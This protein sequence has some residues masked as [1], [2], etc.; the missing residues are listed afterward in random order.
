MN[1]V[2]H[3]LKNQKELSI[4]DNK[5]NEPNKGFFMEKILGIDL[6]TT[7][8]VMAI[9]EHSE[10][11]VIPNNRGDRLMASVVAYTKNE[12]ILVGKSAK[13]QSIVNS[14]RTIASIKRKMGTQ[15]SITIGNKTLTPQEISAKILGK[16]KE[17]AEGYYGEEIKKAVITVPAYFNDNQRQ[18]TKDAGRLAGLEVV[19]IINEPTAAALAYGFNSNDEKIV[20]VYDLGGGTF[21]VS[22]L[23][24][25]SGVF[26]VKATCGNNNLGG[27]DFDNALLELILNQYQE[28]E[29]INLRD[30][31]MALQKLKDE[32]EKV[33]IELSESN[34]A[35]INIPFI[36]ADEKGP[37]HLN[38]PIKRN[39]FE[40]L[41]SDYIEETIRLTD[42]AIKD[43]G[44]TNEDIDNVI[45]VGGSTR[46]PMVQKQVSE[47]LGKPITK[48]IN[49]DEVVALGASIQA[50]IIKG[51][52][53]GIVLVDVT[54]LS[55]GIEIEGGI[56]IPIIERN[57]TIPVTANKLFT[58]IA[59][60]QKSVEIHVLQGERTKCSENI[61]LGRFHL[62]GIRRAKKGEPRIEVT[63]SIDVD[64]IVS[65]SAR[66]L[67]TNANQ[68]ITI[69]NSTNLT[70]ERIKELIEDAKKNKETDEK[71]IKI[72]K[73]QALIE[74]KSVLLKE[75]YE[76]YKGELTED[77]INEIETL[78]EKLK[79]INKSE[80]LD[81]LIEIEEMLSFT[82]GEL[83]SATEK[84]ELESSSEQII[85]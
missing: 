83:I 32:V 19:R 33:K 5:D 65:V 3:E 16:L 49:P 59:D 63:F 29:G 50:A 73:K 31:K 55:L 24:I 77:L 37:K 30:D 64:G 61:S 39:D 6:G 4:F 56:F 44:L 60:N 67:D 42:K 15:D 66:D 34:E 54:P 78:E 23:E 20:L 8:S 45:L 47:L 85:N 10:P 43:A 27:D 68:E 13:N 74:Q 1:K 2:S 14:D 53:T 9:L 70:E 48:G 46:I 22:I 40:D 69:T 18:A 7:N 81:T 84:M 71:Y 57:T 80:D 38:I 62:N 21:D 17:D 41:I 26:E 75:N 51:E 35:E 79:E 82:L 36:S 76:K 28:N 52:A 25:G 12:E 58:T 11:V 72:Q